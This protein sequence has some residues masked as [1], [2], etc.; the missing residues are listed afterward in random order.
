MR[1]KGEE[2]KA[3]ERKWEEDGRAGISSTVLT[4]DNSLYT[5]RRHARAFVPT[6]ASARL[7]TS[8]RTSWLKTT[9]TIIHPII[10][11]SI[12]DSAISKTF[13][14]PPVR[15]LPQFPS[16]PQL[17]SVQH[18]AR[19]VSCVLLAAMLW[20]M[21]YDRGGIVVISDVNYV[22][23]SLLQI[24]HRPQPLRFTIPLSS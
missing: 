21:R 6:E 24:T 13:F 10:I 19:T 16:R 22:A 9:A 3:G 2:A 11:W 15:S 8:S 1:R 5:S 17:R 7:S 20:D 23:V 18:D 12:P 4:V 14:P